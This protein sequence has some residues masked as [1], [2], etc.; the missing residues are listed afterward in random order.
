VLHA[1]NIDLRRPAAPRLADLQPD[2]Q[3][4]DPVQEVDGDVTHDLVAAPARLPAYE[5]AGDDAD[6]GSGECRRTR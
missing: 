5:H 4:L 6:G 3:E 1:V 2:R